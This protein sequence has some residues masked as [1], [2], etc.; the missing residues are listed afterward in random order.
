MVFP[1][2]GPLSV[3]LNTD[4]CCVWVAATKPSVCLW[5]GFV[6]RFWLLFHCSAW[7][8]FPLLHNRAEEQNWCWKFRGV[9]GLGRAGGER[10]VLVTKACWGGTEGTCCGSSSDVC[11]FVEQSSGN[12]WVVQ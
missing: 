9:Q 11:A 3:C 10:A 5:V 4:R 2:Y 12:N 7:R 6:L 8:C 1:A